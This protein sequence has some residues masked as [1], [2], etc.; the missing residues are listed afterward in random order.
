VKPVSDRLL[1]LVTYLR[2]RVQTILWHLG[3]FPLLFMFLDNLITRNMC[4][5]HI[6]ISVSISVI[7]SI[8]VSI[9]YLSLSPDDNHV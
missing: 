3:I 2:P 6:S 7:V 4:C 5:I 8:S 9:D 1:A